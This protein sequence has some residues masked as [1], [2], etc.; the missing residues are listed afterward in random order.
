[1]PIVERG[2]ASS[3]IN[4]ASFA[5]TVF[6]IP[7]EVRMGKPEPRRRRETSCIVAGATPSRMKAICIGLWLCAME[8]YGEIV[9]EQPAKADADVISYEAGG[10]YGCDLP[11]PRLEI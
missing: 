9:D 3:T 7:N 2:S 10:G 11:S 8:W 5:K 1:M 4:R 6:D